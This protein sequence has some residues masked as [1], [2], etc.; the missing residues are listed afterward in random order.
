MNPQKQLRSRLKIASL[1]MITHSGTRILAAA[2]E[3][4]E[5]ESQLMEEATATL[6]KRPQQLK[7]HFSHQKENLQ[8]STDPCVGFVF[9]CVLF[10]DM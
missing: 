8:F 7:L 3:L 9:C 6:K 4:T 2:A 5:M 10:L 1:I